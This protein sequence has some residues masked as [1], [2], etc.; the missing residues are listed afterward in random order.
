[1]QLADALSIKRGE[2]VAFV[3]AGGK[4]TSMAHLA[5]ELRARGWRVLVTTTTRIGA[6]Q[7]TLFPATFCTETAEMTLAARLDDKG[8]V[9]LY[10][11]VLD[12]KVYGIDRERA[13]SL[14]REAGADVLIVEADGARRLPIKAPYAHEPLIPVGATLIVNVVGYRAF[15]QPL[16]DA[17]AYNARAL[18]EST[19]VAYGAT[20]DA[21]VIAGA[22]MLGAAALARQD[23]RFVALLN[24]VPRTAEAQALA[25]QITQLTLIHPD[26]HCVV[27]STEADNGGGDSEVRRRVCAIVLAA[28]LSRRM[29][30]QK[31][32]LPW[33]EGDVVIEHV[34][35]MVKAGGVDDVLVITGANAEAVSEAAHRA[36]ALSLHNPDFAAGEMLSS[37]QAGLRA[38]LNQSADAALVVLGDQ[39]S[40]QSETVRR[41]LDAYAAGLGTIIAPSF[42]MRRGHPILIDRRYWQEV[43]DLPPGSAPRDVINRHNDQIGY[44]ETDD[45]VLRDIDTP[46]AY[47]EERRRAFG[48]S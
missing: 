35:R 20:I 23:C 26:V 44:V 1:M 18:A 39:P 14:L 7:L 48:G 3:G 46:E 11:R 45:S 28:G 9:F 38:A 21:D 41:I 42:N 2:I 22:L 32:L 19:G 4:T 43:L 37:V 25:S 27:V 33:G 40:L 6:E 13:A 15:G 29:G 17:H 12:D 31:I 47:A 30:S 16:D 10:S 5:Q 24:G 8:C 34:I 36:C